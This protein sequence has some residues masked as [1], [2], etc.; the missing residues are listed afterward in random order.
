MFAVVTSAKEVMFSPVFVCLLTGSIK[1]CCLSVCPS[2]TLF[3]YIHM[4]E[5]IVKLL[6]R[7]SGAIILVFYP[8]HQYPIP[9]GT[10]SAGCK[11]HGGG[12]ENF[13]LSTKISVYLGNGTRYA[14]L[15]WKVNGK[16]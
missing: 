8:H 10:T 16:S 7:P 9:K 13:P 11:I 1:N 5:D 2:V 12:W 3:Y 14:Q 4:A 15:L 6:S